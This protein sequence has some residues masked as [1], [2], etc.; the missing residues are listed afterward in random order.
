MPPSRGSSKLQRVNVRVSV[1]SGWRLRV[2]R[3][4]LPVRPSPGAVA[5]RLD[6]ALFGSFAT[7][8]FA[9]PVAWLLGDLSVTSVLWLWSFASAGASMVA[10]RRR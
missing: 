1:A 7:L 3:A 6:V 2:S 10:C 5:L 9:V 4:E 8:P